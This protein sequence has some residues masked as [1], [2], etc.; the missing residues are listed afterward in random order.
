MAR[1]G[2]PGEGGHKPST[3][4]VQAESN[5]ITERLIATEMSWP[6]DR[7]RVIINAI[8]SSVESK[9]GQSAIS[10]RMND[11]TTYAATAPTMVRPGDCAADLCARERL[12]RMIIA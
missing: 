6:V 12:G 5:R 2:D 1:A 3:G 10:E 11:L 4:E 8:P 7:T 9:L